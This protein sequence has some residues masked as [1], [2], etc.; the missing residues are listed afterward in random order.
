M[1]TVLQYLKRQN[2]PY[3]QNDIFIN[4]KVALI[5]KNA[6]SK[7]NLNKA[8]SSLLEQDAIIAKQYGKQWIYCCKQDSVSPEK[9]LELETR[10]NTRSEECQAAKLKLEA[11]RMDL[12][13]QNTPKTCDIP[14]LIHDLNAQNAV[15]TARLVSIKT[16]SLTPLQINAINAN[17]DHAQK[18]EKL[19]KRLFYNM[20]NMIRDAIPGDPAVLMVSSG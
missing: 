8:I 11:V 6:V 10:I 13:I 14:G 16:T 15:L 18:Q 2:R 17:Y 3:N 12:A 5:N 19:R 20:W 7:P 1:D 4:L 9:L